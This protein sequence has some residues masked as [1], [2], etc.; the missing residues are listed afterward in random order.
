M[1]DQVKAW[2]RKWASMIMLIAGATTLF[3][4]AF[5]MYSWADDRFVTQ[6]QVAMGRVNAADTHR[7]QAASQKY[8]FYGTRAAVLRLELR[9]LLQRNPATMTA[10]ER[11]RVEEIKDELR[12]HTAGQQKAL[13]ELQRAD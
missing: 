4:A 6:A 1:P 5:S 9:Y 2:A 8:D 12:I 13:Q 11:V 7:R 10:V 3:G